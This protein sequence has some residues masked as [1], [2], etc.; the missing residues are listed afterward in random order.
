MPG[1]L[2]VDIGYNFRMTHLPMNLLLEGAAQL[3]MVLTDQQLDQFT[4]YYLELVRWNQRINLTNIIGFEEVQVK[5]FL[6]S[7]SA[8]SALKQ[9]PVGGSLIDLGTGAGFPGLPLK[10]V[11]PGLKLALAESVGKK[12]GFL[13]HM[14]RELALDETQVLRGRAEALA[15]DL[16]LRERFDLVSARGLARMSLLLEYCLPFC[17]VGGKTLAWKHAGTNLNDELVAA[18]RA[19]ELLGGEISQIYQVELGGLT[20]GRAVVVVEKV[21]PTPENY[22]R[23]TGIPAK[24][25]L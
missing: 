18:E 11:H 3:G 14:V 13:E 25:P 1:I 6:D 7:L 10:L 24:R 21:R 8:I 20:D 22:P 9:F 5:H 2:D 12:V 15:H 23:R 19:L 4:L 17:R 16:G